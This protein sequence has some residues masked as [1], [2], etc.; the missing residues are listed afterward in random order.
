MRN[1]FGSLLVGGTLLM[2]AA[3]AALTPGPGGLKV[4]QSSLYENHSL[5]FK[6]P[7]LCDET[8]TQYSGYLNVGTNEHYFFWFFES[9]NNPAKDPL[10]VW[11]NGGPGC[12]SMIGL[13]EELGP[14]RVNDDATKAVYNEQGSWNKV[15]NMLFFDQ[16][17]Q[18]GFSYG[19]NKVFSTDQAANFSY[20]F[21]QIFFEAF[22][23]YRQHDFHFF[24]ESYGG[25]YVPSFADYVL[26]QNKALKPTDKL[27]RIN[28]KSI[29]VGNGMTDPL[30][31]NKYLEKMACNSSYGSVLPEQYCKAMNDALPRC[32][33]LTETCYKTN[34]KRDCVKAQNF[35]ADNIEGQYQ[36]SNKSY[37]DVRSPDSAPSNY[38]QF[39]NT[40]ATRDLIGAK[41]PYTE[42]S[43]PVFDNFLSTGDR[44]KSFSSNVADLLNNG[45]RVLIY[46]GDADFIC[47]WYGNYAWVSALNF[48]G[49][50]KFAGSLAAWNVGGKEVGQLQSGGGLAFVRVY[51]AGHEV[52]WYQPVASLAM[53][54]DHVNNKL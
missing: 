25:H 53:F 5:S 19:S 47:N 1:I 16:P 42:C 29:G 9:R 52:P 28:L 14:C 43:G 41:V 54:T 50:K 22:P 7:K 44:I 40:T 23:Q 13:W 10:T 31:Q 27:N 51:E 26:K 48:K 39:I 8:V 35:C 11:L 38:I 18:V 36:F 2:Q 33:K 17:A 12:S 46:A 21:L 24:G 49:A 30:I 20:K 37:Y 32:T 45:V 6:Q 15:S 4:L 34:S 3:S